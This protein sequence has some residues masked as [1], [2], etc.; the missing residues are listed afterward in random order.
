MES[1]KSTS[2]AMPRPKT[3]MDRYLYSSRR[4]AMAP[5]LI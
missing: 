4:N 1:V 2:R 5:D 3:K